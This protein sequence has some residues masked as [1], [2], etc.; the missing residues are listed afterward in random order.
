MTRPDNPFDFSDMMEEIK[1]IEWYKAE[2][3]AARNGQQTA[4]E[5]AANK[6]RESQ[7]ARQERDAAL[8][9]VAYLQK[10]HEKLAYLAIAS[11]AITFI[12]GIITGVMFF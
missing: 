11:M 6:S 7:Q 2:T 8:A 1:D 10:A 3:A 4:M 5:F 12:I 9:A